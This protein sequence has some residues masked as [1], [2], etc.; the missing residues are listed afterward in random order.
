MLVHKSPQGWS[1]TLYTA[2]EMIDAKTNVPCSDSR[3]ELLC[4]IHPL[5]LLSLPSKVV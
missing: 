4:N 5:R 1:F 3:F 2:I